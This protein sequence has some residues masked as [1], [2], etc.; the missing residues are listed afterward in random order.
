MVARS[1]CAS[2]LQ[3]KKDVELCLG[4]GYEGVSEYSV[5]DKNEPLSVSAGRGVGVA[6]MRLCPSLYVKRYQWLQ[7]QNIYYK[8][9]KFAI[10]VSTK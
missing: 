7:L 2:I 6:V 5:G 8:D 9:K 3:D 4:V 1:I 10:E